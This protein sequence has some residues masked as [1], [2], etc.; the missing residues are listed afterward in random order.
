[1]IRIFLLVLFL[2]GIGLVGLPWFS[3]NILARPIGTWPVYDERTG[4]LPAQA[5]LQPAD[6]PMHI[7]VDMKAVAPT[8]LG[9]D[10][11][12]LTLTVATEGRT[13]L[14]KALTFADSVG[15]DTNPQTGEKIFREITGGLE[16]VQAGTYT[17]TFGAGDAEG[18]TMKSVDVLL[19]HDGMAYDPR[20]QPGGFV[21][22]AIGF[23]GLVL[24]FG[25]TGGKPPE[26]PNSQ[27]PQPRWGRG[28]QSS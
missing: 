13:V 18:V 27:P 10:R 6:A 2:G 15:R 14:A 12:V 17:F 28:G 8:K 23:I 24:T 26:N 16:T 22:M 7:L 3:D 1:M 19:K 11:A 25:R 9:K 20:L 4:F 5:Q 21:A